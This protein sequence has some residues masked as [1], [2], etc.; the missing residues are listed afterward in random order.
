MTIHNKDTESPAQGTY[1][2]GIWQILLPVFA[3]ILLF[4]LMQFACLLMYRHLKASGPLF[5]RPFLAG[6]PGLCMTAMI[7]FSM[8]AALFP[9]LREGRVRLDAFRKRVRA[10]AADRG[11]KEMIPIWIGLTACACALCIFGNAQIQSIGLNSES[12]S[13][14]QPVYRELPFLFILLIFAVLT[15]FVEEY[16]FRGILYTG[17]R[18]R[19]TPLLSMLLAAAMFGLYHEELIQGTYAFCMGLLFCISLEVTGD[20]KAPWLLH[21]ISNGL[22]LVISYLGLWETFLKR[23][24]RIGTFACFLIAAGLSGAALIRK[25]ASRN[26]AI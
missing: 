9:V 2:P 11:M 4:S 23:E 15:P 25:N 6:R 22:P 7:L 1:R 10:D 21:S 13:T 18:S 26:D 8:V 19:F 20:L 3:F 14:M 24:W 16:V 17:L 12:V 5:L